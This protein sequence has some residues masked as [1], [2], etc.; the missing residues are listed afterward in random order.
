[1]GKTLLQS[2][3][4]FNPPRAEDKETLNPLAMGKPPRELLHVDM[5]I[6]FQGIRC[7]PLKIEEMFSD[8]SERL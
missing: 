6:N 5:C 1:M 2:T 4:W 3:D 7:P 8:P